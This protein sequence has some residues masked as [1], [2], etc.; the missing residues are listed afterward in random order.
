MYLILHIHSMRLKCLL[1]CLIWGNQFINNIQ[2]SPIN[3][4]S[5]EIGLV[6]N[7][8]RIAITSPTPYTWAGYTQYCQD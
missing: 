4:V 8:D 3:R 1:D 5:E 6:Y 2:W 7:I